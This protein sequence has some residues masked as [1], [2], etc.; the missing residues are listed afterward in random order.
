[1]SLYQNNSIDENRLDDY[2]LIDGPDFAPVLSFSEAREEDRLKKALTPLHA[3]P[4]GLAAMRDGLQKADKK[5]AVGVIQKLQE[6]QNSCDLANE[7]QEKHIKDATALTLALTQV[8]N[9]LSTL[10]DLSDGVQE[11]M[12]D[13]PHIR[14]IS[15][16][17]IR[18]LSDYD[19]DLMLQAI[20][21]LQNQLDDLH[22]QMGV[23]SDCSKAI[24]ELSSDADL[25]TLH[26]SIEAAKV[27]ESARDF[28]NNVISRIND[29]SHRIAAAVETLNNELATM[30]SRILT[31]NNA[32]SALHAAENEASRY[33]DSSGT[34][35]R[36]QH[37]AITDRDELISEYLVYADKALNTVD[38]ADQSIRA[39]GEHSR[40]LCSVIESC[41][42]G[43][44]SLVSEMTS[45]RTDLTHVKSELRSAARLVKSAGEASHLAPVDRFIAESSRLV[46][47]VIQETI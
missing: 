23:L 47:K 43:S 37:K 8:N 36:E 22:S 20:N 34:L 19:P 18:L 10:S 40:K 31:V 26:C 16:P 42:Q 14:A 9:A 35:I 41:R 17:D 12:L 29:L 1:M 3:I 45:A 28:S 27:D 15:T 7:H 25:I 44:E 4:D 11:T 6:V 30:N 24:S 2:S 39:I 38:S 5:I 32:V 33:A 13:P 46:N 21:L